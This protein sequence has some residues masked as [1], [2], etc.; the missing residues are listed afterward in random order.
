MEDDE[1]LARA[2]QQAEEYALCALECALE[3]RLWSCSHRYGSVD[4]IACP[5]D[6]SERVGARSANQFSPPAA[7]K[8]A[9]EPTSAPAD[10]LDKY[11]NSKSI[12]SANFFGSE[13]TQVDS[14][15]LNKFQGS[16]SISSDAFYGT[17]RQRAASG[18]RT[19]VVCLTYVN[20][21][22]HTETD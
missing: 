2:L 20:E 3:L 9:F 15:H 6:D 22:E 12:S 17:G 19:L 8:P 11:K 10:T 14:A 16:Q 7:A 5:L 18:E 21:D 1:A 13:A 4:S